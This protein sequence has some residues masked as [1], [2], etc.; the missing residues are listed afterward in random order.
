MAKTIQGAFPVR[1]AREPIPGPAGVVYR[2][3]PSVTQIK[4]KTNGEYVPQK[5]SCKRM[6]K[7]GNEPQHESSEGAL[8][9]RFSNGVRQVYTGAVSI[10]NG[11][12]WLEYEW[13]VD[14][15]TA[16]HVTIHVVK[17][18][19]KGIDGTYTTVNSYPA[20]QCEEYCTRQNVV[21]W[22]DNEVNPSKGADWAEGKTVSLVINCD[23]GDRYISYQ[24]V[25]DRQYLLP[26]SYWVSKRGND[27]TEGLD[28][29]YCPVT[30]WA[31]GVKFR[32]EYLQDVN[33]KEVIGEN[34][35]PIRVID[36]VYLFDDE[37]DFVSA[38]MCA[39]SHI[40][41]AANKPGSIGGGEYWRDFN[42]MSPVYIPFVMAPNALIKILQSNSMLID[43]KQGV[44]AGMT[45]RGDTPESVRMW[46]GTDF[47]H[48]DEAPFRVT[49]EGKV[50]AT[51]AYVEGDIKV[52]KIYTPF[53][54]LN[55]P[56]TWDA[57]KHGSNITSRTDFTNPTPVITLPRIPEYNGI[58]LYLYCPI[59]SRSSASTYIQM[60]DNYKWKFPLPDGTA[61]D[62][63]Y[64][65]CEENIITVV[66][67]IGNEWVVHSPRPLNFVNNLG[68][69]RG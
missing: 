3:Y 17:D 1:W 29:P 48:R 26:Q 61:R 52:N 66:T 63:K 33:G 41:S 54:T 25:V 47:A 35:K 34:G 11:A 24:K 18:G 65:R 10:P 27:G 19:D 12:E 56:F 31:E 51:G 14:N 5:V 13:V 64:Y 45:G 16:D 4:Q 15:S 50:H 40:S 57:N 32:N 49:A 21:S 22:P 7:A 55:P 2:L 44:T 46:S 39:K 58:T 60:S 53:A 6:V 69:H 37:G 59:A 42:K 9:Y 38:H 23:N 62:W 28:A 8:Y 68:E 43:G 30:Q 20:E 36:T 67:C